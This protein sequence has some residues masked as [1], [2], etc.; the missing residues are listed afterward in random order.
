MK[1]LPLLFI[2]LLIFSCTKKDN[3]EIEN[4]EL[5]DCV[6]KLTIDNRRGPA[7]QRVRVQEV[8]N[9]FHFWLNTDVLQSDL[10]EFVVDE[11]CNVVCTFC[12]ECNEP[13]CSKEYE[14]D[15]W[16]TIWEK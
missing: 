14:Y 10:S 11:K 6:E 9:E 12:S 15:D 8:K 2:F 5:P 7:I 3:S 16:V 13:L 4:L 1:Q